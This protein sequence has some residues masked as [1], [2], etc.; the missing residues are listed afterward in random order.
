MGVSRVAVDPRKLQSIAVI[1][2]LVDA[3]Q[4]GCSAAV[5]ID[6]SIVWAAARGLA[7]L[8]TG[9]KITTQ[10]RFDIASISKQFTATAILQ[11]E[12]EGKL[13]LNDTIA[14]YV[15]GL[16]AWGKTIT[17][18]A[19]MH[20][21]SRIPDFWVP[22][23]HVGIG[24]SSP[25]SQADVV[26]AIRRLPRLDPG[27][28]YEY[29]NSNYVLLAEVVRVVSGM[30]LPDYLNEHIFTPLKLDMVLDPVL[31]APDVALSYD[32][33]NKLVVAGW[34]VFG[35]TGIHTTSSELAIWGDQYR[36]STIVL[37]DFAT[38][39]ADANDP[40]EPRVY[41]AGIGILADGSLRSDGRWG[42]TTSTLQISADRHTSI[43]VMCAGHLAPRFPLADQLWSVW[44][45]PQGD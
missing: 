3:N 24:F 43:V 18:S 37:A 22:L 33:N 36:Q 7:N 1:N 30:A 5:E 38:D 20:H 34:D 2:G 45:G 21:T 13:S 28:G 44:I 25:A 32:D 29:S 42:G 14:Q 26:A 8:A 39:A 19:L 16:P 9:E 27:S 15:P 41:G 23:S 17:L 6:G 40:A 4:P 12:R 35:P 31:T 10:T 11:L